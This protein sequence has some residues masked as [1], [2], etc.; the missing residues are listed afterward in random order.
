V[1]EA[2]AH[3]DVDRWRAWAVCAHLAGLAIFMN[4][5][6]GG[7][8]PTIIIYSL[9]HNDGAYIRE[10]ARSALNMQITIAIFDAVCFVA[11]FV[12]W[13][14]MMFGFATAPA[15]HGQVPV[16]PPQLFAAF[17]AI[18]V[19]LLVNLAVIV[20]NVVAAIAASDGK[21]GRYVAAIEFVRP[22][23][24]TGAGIS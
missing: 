18:A 8:I 20:N 10:N 3:S 23:A 17:S 22:P 24:R 1:I 11:F 5:P 16:P 4:V 9:R 19:A 21:I 2:A 6:F 14:W 15:H 12:F 7:L 13:L